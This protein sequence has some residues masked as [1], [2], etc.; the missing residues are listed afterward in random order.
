MQ[1]TISMT[2]VPK[3]SQCQ[4]SAYPLRAGARISTSIY[5]V[6]AKLKFGKMH[7]YDQYLQYIYSARV[8]SLYLK[9][10][11]KRKGR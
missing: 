8:D 9:N 3:L 1:I 5:K 10:K 4:Q 11:N 2:C 6:T 7:T